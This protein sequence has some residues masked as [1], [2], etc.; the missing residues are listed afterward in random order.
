MEMTI[1]ELKSQVKKSKLYNTFSL[2]DKLYL[3]YRVSPGSVVAAR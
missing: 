3:H 1:A 2:N